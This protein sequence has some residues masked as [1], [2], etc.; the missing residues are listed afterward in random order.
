M[1]A[2]LKIQV[3]HNGLRSARYPRMTVQTDTGLNTNT[4]Y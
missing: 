2:V 1:N 3:G 4:V